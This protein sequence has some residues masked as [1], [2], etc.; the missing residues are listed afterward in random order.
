MEL[1]PVPPVRLAN[2]HSQADARTIVGLM[3]AYAQDPM[4][5]GKALPR[6]TREH[7]VEKLAEY[8]AIT[9]LAFVDGKAVGLLNAFWGFSTFAC[10][11][12]INIHD[13]VVLKEYRGMGLSHALLGQ[14]EQ[15][16]RSHNCCK[17]TLEVLSGNNTAKAAYRSFGFRAYELDPD[18]GQALFWEKTIS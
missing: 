3:D 18:K 15:I 5:G 8:N 1:H 6:Y 16:G 10:Q 2:Y 11:P 17:L 7:L 4:G 14:L 12:L 9:L 13:L